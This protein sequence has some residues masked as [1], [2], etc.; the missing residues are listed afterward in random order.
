MNAPFIELTALD[1]SGSKSPL[2]ALKSTKRRR[3][4]WRLGELVMRMDA[5]D[6]EAITEYLNA[7]YALGNSYQRTMRYMLEC[8][9]R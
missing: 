4:T 8:A 6:A 9:T 7:Q 2:A 3:I 1:K 5:D